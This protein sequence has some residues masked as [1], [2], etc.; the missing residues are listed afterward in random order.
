MKS[1]NLNIEKILDLKKWQSLQDAISYVAKLALIT[2]D[3]KGIPVTSHSNCQP[4]CK[5]VRE[6][7]DLSKFCQKCDSR[8]GLEAVRLNKPYIYLCHFHIVDVAIPLI[9]DDKYIGAIMA[10]QVKLSDEE[11]PEL[12]QILATNTLALQKNPQLFEAYQNLPTLTLKEIDAVADMLHHLCNYIV[13]E[14]MDKN[15]LLEMYHKV[16]TGKN[17]IIDSATLSGYTFKNIQD[18]KI[19][20][21]NTLLNSFVKESSISET[22][23]RNSI[24]SPAFE[25][26]FNHKSEKI[27]QKEM[28]VLCHTS[29]SYFSKLFSKETGE[30]FPNYL[31]HI[32]IEWAKQMLE[33]SDMPI[34]QIS[35]ELGFNE[36]GYFIKTFKKWEG[37]T[38]SHY[39]K[40]YKSE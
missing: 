3:Y 8:G 4:F 33:S 10:G 28:A 25:Y 29:T 13:E 21:A 11:N 18:V 36:S 30:S 14:A 22:L 15:L 9:I 38:P 40:Y 34:S 31:S 32:K 16:L 39:R 6:D 19:Q 27:S 7:S 24:L 1:E 23:P 37:T 2:V 17:S 12:E 26:I 35:D 5:L 20:I